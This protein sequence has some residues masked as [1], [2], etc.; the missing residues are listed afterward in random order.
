MPPIIIVTGFAPF[1]GERINPSWEVARSLDGDTIAGLRVKSLRLPVNCVRAADRVAVAVVHYR[2][3][4]ILGLGQARGR[5]ALSI[6][7]IAINLFENRNGGQ[8][9]ARYDGRALIRDAPAAYFSRL[10]I[11][12]I[13]KA[14]ERRKVP[15]SVSLSA[16]SY[17]C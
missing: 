8:L 4:A 16:G 11:G 6:E 15:A 7:R 2:P 12:A 9:D 10:P 5:P 3:R 14:L 13:L 1:G 17:A